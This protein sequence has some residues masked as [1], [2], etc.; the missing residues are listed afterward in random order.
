[1]SSL[2]DAQLDKLGIPRNTEVTA[3]GFTFAYFMLPGTRLI[4]LSHEKFGLKM[5]KKLNLRLLRTTDAPCT[6][7][8][9]HGLATAKRQ[10]RRTS[11]AEGAHQV[12]RFQLFQRCR[13]ERDSQRGRLVRRQAGR[14][15]CAAERRSRCDEAAWRHA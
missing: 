7:H 13:V 3:A 1:M 6:V 12:A 14:M 15:T 8:R 4:S 5:A 9:V 11:L 2:A 10:R